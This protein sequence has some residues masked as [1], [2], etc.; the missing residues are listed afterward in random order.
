MRRMIAA[1]ILSSALAVAPAALAQ[2]QDTT[3]PDTGASSTMHKSMPK[4]NK[5]MK[6]HQTSMDQKKTSMDQKKY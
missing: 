4:K 2:T 1:L 5:H 3:S 6:K